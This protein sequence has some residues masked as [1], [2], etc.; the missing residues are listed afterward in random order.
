[1]LR[2]ASGAAGSG[3]THGGAARDLRGEFE[4][5][6]AV[7]D[8]LE[9]GLEALQ[10]LQWEIRDNQARYRDLLDNQADVL[11]RR[12]A[13]GRLIFVNRAFCRVFGVESSAVLGRPFAPRVLA[14]DAPAPLAAGGTMRRQRYRQEIETVRGARWFEWEEHAVSLGEFGAAEVQCLGRDITE[15]L[16]AEQELSEAR[17]QAEAANRAKSRFLA[18]MSHEIRTPMNGI[19]GITALLA[20]TDLQPEQRTYA[21]AIE[22]SARA[23]LALIDEILDFSKIEADKLQLNCAPLVLEDCVQDVV[24]LLAPKAYEKGIEIAWSIDPSLPRALIGDEVRVRQILTN[25]IGNAIKFTDCGGVLVTVGHAHARPRPLAGDMLAI[26]VA[27]RDSGI[28]IAVESM[29]QLFAEFEQADGAVRRHGGTGLGLAISR[30]LTRAMGGD[31][32]VE[33]VPARGSTFTAL[34]NLQLVD[35]DTAS[36]R[37]EEES[38][39]CHH[40]LLALEKPMERSA[41][42]LS[43]EGAGIPVEESTLAEAPE[44]AD[45]AAKAQA[46]FTGIIVDGSRG[47]AAA[48]QALRRAR[49]AAAPTPIYAIVVLDTAAKAEFGKFHDAGFDAYL[50]RPV[51]PRTM[52]ALLAGRLP[53]D[54]AAISDPEPQRF[55]LNANRTAPLSVL[56]AEDNAVNTLLARHVLEKAGCGVRVSTNGLEA[57]DAVRRSLLGL[58]PGYDLIL[59]DAHMPVLDGLEAT[60][61]IK[62]LYATTGDRAARCPP[63]IAVTASAFDDDRR[64]CLAAGM[65][66]YLA[67]PFERDA[68]LRLVDRW[69]CAK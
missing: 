18:A 58:E 63:I 33:S 24:E 45:A 3:R 21:H 55:C 54:D 66:D 25:L 31:I 28:G 4:R 68:L 15:R 29:P 69:C 6:L 36:S 60:R 9:R 23:L 51:R 7:G 56:L 13:E 47:G 61:Q 2:E 49:A 37:P 26:A 8:R 44:M 39:V 5:F 62:E 57:V 42:R 53:G 22:G 10:D 16:H 35:C 41:L 17:R 52:L 59:M 48:S 43:L 20:D 12:D 1:M 30:R 67:K 19:L 11:I 38:G 65:D 34:M 46:P 32:L 64:R 50:L 14:G 40:V 27:V